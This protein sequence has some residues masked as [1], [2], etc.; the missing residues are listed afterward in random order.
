MPIEGVADQDVDTDIENVKNGK[1]TLLGEL[2]EAIIEFQT[3][4]D[5]AGLVENLAHFEENESDRA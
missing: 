5:A 2:K 4:S 1:K 3:S